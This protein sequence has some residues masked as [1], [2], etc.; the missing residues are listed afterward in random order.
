MSTKA[1]VSTLTIA[2][3][4]AAPAASAHTLSKSSAKRHAVRAGGALIGSIGGSPVY[5]CER[6][7][8]HAFICR[9]SVVALEG[10]VCSATVR[11]AY[12]GHEDRTVSRRVLSGPVCE[13]PEV[14]GIP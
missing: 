9:I 13:P 6:R 8:A 4:V 11:V 5:D 3:A 12:R 2:L 1:L 7:N 10:D 14:A